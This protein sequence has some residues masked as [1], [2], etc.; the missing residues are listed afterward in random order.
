MPG[1][2]AFIATEKEAR[3]DF[4]SGVIT[5]RHRDIS[6]NGSIV[7]DDKL[8]CHSIARRQ[9]MSYEEA[10]RHL[11]SISDKIRCDLAE[12]GEVS[13][14]MVG[15]LIMD[16]DGYISFQPRK[17]RVSADILP[18]LSIASTTASAPESISTAK[19][20]DQQ[21]A[22]DN[23]QPNI[24][25]QNYYVFRIHKQVAH[26]AAM[27]ILVLT[28]GLSMLI[29]INHDNEQKA[30]VVSIPEFIYVPDNDETTLD[31][32]S[33]IDEI[34]VETDSLEINSKKL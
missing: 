1:I 16:A 14:G 32:Y 23:R 31:T 13:L 28:I 12:E 26:A 4:E 19:P 15:K 7:N 25:N 27:L 29:P 20:G 30:S 18:N 11:S 6:F 34:V 9:R 3:I 5:P 10:H 2:G 21:P 24:D 17:S 22:S 33:D 8:L